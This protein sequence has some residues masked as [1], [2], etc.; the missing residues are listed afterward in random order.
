MKR[1]LVDD[2]EPSRRHLVRTLT[3]AKYE[4]AGRGPSGESALRLA[5]SVA[6]DVIVVAVGL[7]D[8]HNDCWFIKSRATQLSLSKGAHR[9]YDGASFFG[10]ERGWDHERA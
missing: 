8:W 10:T 6:P 4:I 3:E 7:P 9:S 1:V 2:H 5:R